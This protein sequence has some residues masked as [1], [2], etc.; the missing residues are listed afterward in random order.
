MSKMMINT[1]TGA[2]VIVVNRLLLLSAYKSAVKNRCKKYK[3]IRIPAG[4]ADD[5]A[6]ELSS[7]KLAKLFI[8]S[9]FHAMPVK[10]CR[11]KFNR[12]YPP[13]SVC[14]GGLCWERYQNY[15]DRGINDGS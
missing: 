14:F 12:N 6:K 8:K 1:L 4:I 10:F 2:N 5:V 3:M 13:V 11:E 9:Q 15:L 7:S